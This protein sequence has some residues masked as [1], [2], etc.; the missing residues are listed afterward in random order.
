MYKKMYKRTCRDGWFNDA[1]VFLNKVAFPVPPVTPATPGE[2]V[3]APPT[4]D[5]EVMMG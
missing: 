1:V 2:G 5:L 3:A 4:V